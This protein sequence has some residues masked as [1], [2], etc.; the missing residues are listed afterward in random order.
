MSLAIP[1]ATGELVNVLVEITKRLPEPVT[2]VATSTNF[3]QQLFGNTQM[4][5][6]AIKLSSLFLAN[7]ALTFA[8]V[9]MVS[10]VGENLAARL[11]V[12]L[13]KSIV[14]QDIL[15]FDERKCGD[16]LNRLTADVQN[17][18]SSV[19]STIS[20]G[21][22]ALTQTVGGITSL[23]IMSPQLTLFM[24]ATLPALYGVGSLYGR[25]LRSVSESAREADA[26]STSIANEVTLFT[27]SICLLQ[28]RTKKNRRC[29][30]FGR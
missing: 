29:Q 7:S 28:L 30:T 2:A 5:V 11:R 27:P 19:K 16:L 4:N 6:A 15:F 13:F 23:Y 21:L 1:A 9:A 12:R 20:Q 3:V 10:Q 24:C 8:Y 25:F 18:K 22:K 26:W 17:F 14:V